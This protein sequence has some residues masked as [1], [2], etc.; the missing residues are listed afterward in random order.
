MKGVLEGKKILLGVTGGIAAYKAVYLLRLFRIDGAEVKV[1]MTESACEFV[2]PLT[3]EALSENPV[4]IRMF[5]GGVERTTVSPIEH[6][7][8]ARWPDLA[9]VAPATAHTI[10]KFA[11]AAADD[12][13]STVICAYDG[14]VVLAPAMNDVMWRNTA[15]QSNLRKL[16]SRGFR[17][18]PPEKG[19]LACGY[20]SEGRMAEPDKI[21]EF[22]KVVVNSSFAGLDVL[23]SAGGTEEDLDPVRVISN[24]SS[25]RMGFAL[26]EAA[27]NRGARVTVVAARVSVPPPVGVRLIRVRTSSEMAQVLH[28]EFPE[29]DVLVMAAAVS[30]FRPA[31]PLE[32]KQKDAS[33]S[34]ELTRTEDIL[35][36]LGGIKGDR[37]VIGFAVETENLDRNARRKLAGKNCDL[38][39]ANNPL[40]EGAAFE[41]ETNAVTVYNGEGKV[42]STGLKSK[43]EI[44]DIIFEIACKEKAFQKIL[45]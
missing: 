42:L 28:R 45:D 40:E 38:M 32:R 8:L 33:W 22:V 31:S 39:V 25:G 9:V 43:H 15:T 16:A 29:H 3:F 37:F 5:A 19:A 17:V 13:L 24:R 6:I 1:I 10:A 41:H 34:L 12:L 20:E 14:P 30:D 27:R 35:Q 44:A 18:V 26:A 36:S 11:G 23:V 21:A 7:D 4:H 2:A